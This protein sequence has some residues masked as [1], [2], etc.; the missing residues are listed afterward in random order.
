[1]VWV[2]RYVWLGYVGMSVCKVRACR[3]GWR[4]VGGVCRYVGVCVGLVGMYG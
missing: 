4:Y 2:C 3:C 1:M